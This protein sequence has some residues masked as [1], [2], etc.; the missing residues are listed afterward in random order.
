MLPPAG[1][2]NSSTPRP[3]NL[4]SSGPPQHLWQLAYTP[5]AILCLRD[6][7][8]NN[9]ETTTAEK[10]FPSHSVANALGFMRISAYWHTPTLKTAKPHTLTDSWLQGCCIF[11]LVR[12]V[13]MCREGE[14]GGIRGILGGRLEKHNLSHMPAFCTRPKGPVYCH[15]FCRMLLP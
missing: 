10:H 15:G 1:W 4:L 12:P 13:G 14:G 7:K 3:A 8:E 6:S 9:N 11:S 2:S 5:M